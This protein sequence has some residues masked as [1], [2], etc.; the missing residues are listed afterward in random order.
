[1]SETFPS[2]PW[3]RFHFFGSCEI[4]QPDGPVHLETAK[5]RALLVYLASNPGPQPRHTLMGLL[6]GELPEAKARRNLRRALWNL[7]RQ[8]AG[9]NLPPPLLTDRETVCFNRE[10]AHWSDVEAFE[11]ACSSLDSAP[12]SLASISNLDV[13][14]L[15]VELYQGE[16]LEGFHVGDALAF[17]EWAL[18]ERERLHVMALQALQR[19]VEGYA[20]QDK[21]DKALLCARRLLALDPWR[22]EAH[23][24]LM[25]LLARSGQ[26]AEALAQYESCKRRS[27]P[28]PS[29]SPP[30][31]CRPRPRP[32]SDGPGSWPRLPGCWLMPTAGC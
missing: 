22:E 26:R 15:A 10:V 28:A 13:L 31:I 29:T 6:W 16:F 7:R 11:T 12:R 2:K 30:P 8:L 5:T 23:R 18:T 1:M 20:S 4:S 21:V 9:P 25:R 19:L 27:E 17:E 3:L 14:R 24:W 32:L